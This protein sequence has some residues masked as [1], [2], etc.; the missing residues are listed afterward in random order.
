MFDL[1]QRAAWSDP[2]QEL[3][4]FQQ[5]IDRAFGVLNDRTAR[6]F[7]QLNLWAGEDGI[8]VSGELPGISAEALQITMQK[9]TLT[10]SGERASSQPGAE[11][12]ALRRELPS[13]RFTRTVTLPFVVDADR[14]SARSDAGILVIHL[15]RPESDRPKRI[16]VATA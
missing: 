9:N 6:E 1:F 15:P 12:T 8:I 13:G 10:L 4:R 14:V 3:R 16:H 2:F 5:D 7:P 11:A